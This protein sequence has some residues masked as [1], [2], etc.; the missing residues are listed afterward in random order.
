MI[1]EADP[2]NRVFEEHV[3]PLLEGLASPLVEDVLGLEGLVYWKIYGVVGVRDAR[4]L[5]RR[6][7]LLLL[8]FHLRVGGGGR[9]VVP[10][11]APLLHRRRHA[12]VVSVAEPRHTTLREYRGTTR[13]LHTTV[14]LY[15]H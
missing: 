6:R 13:I 15:K 3:N 8:L 4:R 7:G 12:L 1:D 9:F 2:A 5:G 14:T 11:V 10:R